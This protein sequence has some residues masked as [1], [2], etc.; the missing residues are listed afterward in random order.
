MSYP[1]QPGITPPAP[2]QDKEEPELWNEADIPS[3][4][5]EGDAEPHP[6]MGERDD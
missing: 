4:D 2:G 5:K 1:T 6:A 3:D